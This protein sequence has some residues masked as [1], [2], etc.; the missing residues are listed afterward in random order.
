MRTVIRIINLQRRLLG[1]SNFPV[2]IFVT[3]I[4]FEIALSS[5]KFLGTN[6]LGDALA[7]LEYAGNIVLFGKDAENMQSSD[8]LK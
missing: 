4:L 1:L 8:H 7:Y 5:S 3:D 2:L 6:L